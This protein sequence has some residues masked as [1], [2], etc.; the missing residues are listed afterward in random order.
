MR[1]HR[2]RHRRR[3]FA[4]LGVRELE[5]RCL[6]TGESA[7]WLGQDDHDLAGPSS[8]LAPDN[9]QDIHIALSGLPT[10]RA[11]VK[12]DI[13]GD[14][15]GEWMNNGPYGPWAAALVRSPGATTA[16]LFMD[17]YQ[18]ETGRTFW[19]A[20]TSDDSSTV[21]VTVAGGTA[22][23]NLRMPE[24]G[25]T[26]VWIGQDGQDWTG[27]S[28]DVGPNGFQ[29]VHIALGNLSAGVGVG[30]RSVGV[31]GTGVA[32]YSGVNPGKFWD[33]EAI[34]NPNDSTK[35]DLFFTSGDL[36][37]LTRLLQ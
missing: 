15:G 3:R 22:D 13:L 8:T 36:Y 4:E 28:P 9:V 5:P 19:I 12:A 35:A 14:G 17:P 24:T 23:P 21:T 34:P 30:F 33:A 31:T 20:L 37:G 29:D 7:I 16:D 2:D 18:V 32:W 6:L 11:I 10:D 26:A 1:T 25:L 27:P